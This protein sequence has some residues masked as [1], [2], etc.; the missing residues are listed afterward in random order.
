LTPSDQGKKLSLDD[1]L[2]A[3]WQ[4]GFRYELIHGRLDVSPLPNL[5]HDRLRKWLERQ[6]EVY[7]EQRPDVINYVLG[8]V[9]IILALPDDVSAPE[10]DLVAYNNFPHHVP[11]EDLDWADV[12][13]A[14][15]VEIISAETPAKDLERNPALYLQV[16]TLRE[17][18]VI[19]PRDESHDRPSMVVYRRRGHR[20]QKPIEV[21]PG[22]A[23]ATRFLPGFT[24]VLD[25]S[26]T[27]G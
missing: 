9:R 4:E 15:A 12:N 11:F 20:W 17:Y 23:Y 21:P 24:L 5:P 1:F 2:T 14:L 10:A 3:D 22:G 19:D 25:R 8:P 26:Q 16:P 6:L 18:W 13:P 27:Q 7:A